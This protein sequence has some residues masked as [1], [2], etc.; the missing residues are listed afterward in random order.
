MENRSASLKKRICADMYISLVFV[1]I[2]FAIG[3][4]QAVR[5]ISEKDEF[6]LKRSIHAFTGALAIFFIFMILNRVSKTGKPFDSTVINYLRT[7]ALTIIVGGV[8]PFFATMV[9]GVVKDSG[10]SIEIGNIDILIP[11]VGVAL[12]IVSEIFVYGRDLQEDNDL[13]A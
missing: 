2:E 9:L 10:F 4:W 8:L 13:I 1:A 5:F 12:G 6:A 3:L 7:A 11:L